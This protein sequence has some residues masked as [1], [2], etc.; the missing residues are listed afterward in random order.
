MFLNRI[1]FRL[2]LPT[3]LLVDISGMPAGGSQTKGPN[4][5]SIIVELMKQTRYITGDFGKWGLGIPG[6]WG[7]QNQQRFYYWY[8]HWN[9]DQAH[10]CNLG[11]LW[12]N[13]K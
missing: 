11:Y 2:V 3:I 10:F 8:D 13:D 9:Q 1:S 6:S 12:E 5:I 4:I 7:L